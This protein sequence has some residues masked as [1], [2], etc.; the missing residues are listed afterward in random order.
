MR[1]IKV[2]F[3]RGRN[4]KWAADHN[5]NRNSSLWTRSWGEIIVEQEP[6]WAQSLPNIFFFFLRHKCSQEWL[7]QQGASEVEGP[8]Y[9]WA[10]LQYRETVTLDLPSSSPGELK[11]NHSSDSAL[12]LCGSI[13]QGYFRWLRW[14]LHLSVSIP[15]LQLTELS[16]LQAGS[17]EGAWHVMNTCGFCSL[18]SP[19]NG[20]G[21]LGLWSWCLPDKGAEGAS[22]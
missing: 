22:R 17:L 16:F 7:I 21:Q 1:Q 5:S 2:G 8:G 10:R 3:S 4:W 9:K 19:T 6:E 13:L 11:E 18:C 15:I 12:C 20:Q 14:L